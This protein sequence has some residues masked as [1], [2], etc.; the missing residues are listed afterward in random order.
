MT[1]CLSV[2]KLRSTLECPD[3]RPGCSIELLI[4]AGEPHVSRIRPAGDLKERRKVHAVVPSKS[5]SFSEVSC[6]PTQPP[7]YVQS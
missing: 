3:R 1:S 5:V 2:R 6:L 7:G 4:E